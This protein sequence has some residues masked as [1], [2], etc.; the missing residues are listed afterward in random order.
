MTKQ[1][2]TLTDKQIEELVKAYVEYKNAE[3]KF[4]D[5]K[6]KYTKDLVEG[7]F[8]AEG[9]G[10]IIKTKFTRSSLNST[11]LS[12]EHPEINLD[13]Y[14]DTTETTSVTVK[15]KMVNNKILGIF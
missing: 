6:E 11:R 13:E 10:E 14:K 5:L 9:I 8:S 2:K 12:E 7:K 4:K 3:Q 1:I 15:N